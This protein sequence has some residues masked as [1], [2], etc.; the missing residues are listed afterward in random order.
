M[1]L[2]ACSPASENNDD[3]DDAKEDAKVETFAALCANSNGVSYGNFSC[4][5]IN[6]KDNQ[7]IKSAQDICVTGIDE[8]IKDITSEFSVS[9]TEGVIQSES[10]PECK[11]IIEN[12]TDRFAALCANEGVQSCESD[13]TNCVPYSYHLYCKGAV[14]PKG[15]LLTK[16]QVCN[17]DSKYDLSVAEIPISD[18]QVDLYGDIESAQC[19]E[20]MDKFGGEDAIEKALV[21]GDL[22]GGILEQSSTPTTSELFILTVTI[23]GLAGVKSFDSKI[24][25]FPASTEIGNVCSSKYNSGTVIKLEPFV[26]DIFTNTWEG[27]DTVANNICSVTLTSNKEVIV[28]ITDSP[29]IDPNCVATHGKIIADSDPILTTPSTAS[30][31]FELKAQGDKYVPGSG[32]KGIKIVKDVGNSGLFCMRSF[33]LF[34]VTSCLESGSEFCSDTPGAKLSLT[35][36]GGGSGILRQFLHVRKKGQNSTQLE[37]CI[38]SNTSIEDC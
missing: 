28:K 13:G 37:I 33:T 24:D 32:L 38:R 18:I 26:L 8:F 20:Y 4:K 19:Q 1:G 3:D 10:D 5:K 35:S 30:Q 23:E 14:V 25:C 22:T 2:L 36:K 34:S 15:E 11:S 7:N 12:S 9:G 6:T 29:N 27:C 21:S 16:T 31:I 17:A